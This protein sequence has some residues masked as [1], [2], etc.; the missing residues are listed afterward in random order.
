ME[1]GGGSQR[2][3]FIDFVL[4]GSCADVR[5]EVCGS[6]PTRVAQNDQ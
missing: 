4:Y 2:D 6:Y 3:F 5:P 1:L